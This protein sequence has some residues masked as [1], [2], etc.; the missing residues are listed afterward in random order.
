MTPDDPAVVAA[1]AEAERARARFAG[2]AR[3]LQARV[4]PAT[5]ARGAWDS[6]KVKGADL[7]EDAVDAVRSRPVVATGVLVAATLFLAREPMLELASRLANGKPPKK[8]PTKP[9]TETVS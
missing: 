3:E 2:T 7:A 8:K 4:S 1:R 5:L 6:A 9:K